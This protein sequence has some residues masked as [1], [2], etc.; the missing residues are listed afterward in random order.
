MAV[1]FA[2]CSSPVKERALPQIGSERKPLPP[3]SVD[4]AVG[5]SE[6]QARLVLDAMFRDAGLRILNDEPL[7]ESLMEVMLDGYDPERGVGYEYIAA[8]ESAMSMSEEEQQAVTEEGRILVVRSCS[9]EEL[10]RRA[11]EFLAALPAA[12]DAGVAADSP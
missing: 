2:S 3:V 5:I 8:S 1:G 7:G 12:P 6:A 11:S 10:R 9:M 4:A